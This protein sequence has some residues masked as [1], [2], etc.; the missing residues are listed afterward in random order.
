M[1]QFRITKY[2]PNLRNPAG[3]FT[4]E[5]WTSYSDIGST[6]E[7][8]TLTEQEYARVESAYITSAIEL[9]RESG[10]NELTVSGLEQ[11]VGLF[12][13]WPRYSAQ[14]YF[15]VFSRSPQRELLVPLREQYWRLCPFR[16]RLLYVRWFT[17]QSW[18]WH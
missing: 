10:I 12:A 11:N 15:A 5:Q 14:F 7:N 6:F 17:I 4:Q 16:L 2:D 18:Q 13:K 8:G 3:A 9:L 1:Y